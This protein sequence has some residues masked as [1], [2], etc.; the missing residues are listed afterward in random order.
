MLDLPA[1]MLATT[2]ADA[3]GWRQVPAFLAHAAQALSVRAVNGMRIATSPSES[4]ASFQEILNKGEVFVLV[5]QVARR[6]GIPDT[7]PLPLLELV[8]RSYALGP[9]PALWAVEGLGHDDAVSYFEAGVPPR[10]LLTTAPEA[11]H[12]PRPSLLMLHAGIGLGFAERRLEGTS[13]STPPEVLRALVRDVL[14]LCR[15]S[16]RPGDL[17]AAIESLGL[18][19]G[20][21]HGPLVP[22]VDR[23]LRELDEGGD[24]LGFYWHGVG[25]SLYFRLVNFLPCSTWPVFESARRLAPDPAAR[26]NAWAGLAWAV[27]LVNQRQPRILAELLIDPHGAELEVDDA[28]ANGVASSIVMRRATTP[29]A[30]FLES[31][32]RFRPEGGARV[33]AR[34]RRLVARP[35]RLALDA[36]FPALDAE[37]R[38]GSVFRYRRLP[39]LRDGAGHGPGGDG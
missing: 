28:F 27:T 32:I 8:A 36:Y 16:S 38:L 12:L 11:R 15:E 10:G 26:R 5:R 37:D 22:A 1:Q 21:L 31:L 13:L 33:E 30:P 14:A 4:T 39:G 19:T 9:F 3:I 29:G 17:G 34:W 2:G 24:V 23:A 25:R 18:V 20:L 6:I 7:F 35:C